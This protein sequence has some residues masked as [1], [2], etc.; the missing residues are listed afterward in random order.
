MRLMHRRSAWGVVGFAIVAAVNAHAQETTTYTYD[1]KGR[2]VTVARSGGPANGTTTNYT[3]D[4]ADNRSNVTVANSPNGVSNG[5]GNGAA[6]VQ[7]AKYVVVP[8]NGY[9]LIKIN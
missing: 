6:T 5:D 1:A 9:T 4:P 2:V 7:P 3:Y 8:L